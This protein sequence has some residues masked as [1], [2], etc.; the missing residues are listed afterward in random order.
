MTTRYTLLPNLTLE[1]VNKTLRRSRILYD[2]CVTDTQESKR[3]A[4]QTHITGTFQV[5]TN[6]FFL[7]KF[8]KCIVHFVKLCL[9]CHGAAMSKSLGQIK[10]C[11]LYFVLFV[12]GHFL[13]PIKWTTADWDKI[14]AFAWTWIY[15]AQY[16]NRDKC[17]TFQILNTWW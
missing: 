3:D 7:F 4:W 1:T 17:C 16:F 11:S 15:F 13:L 14:F 8:Q 6:N 5:N 2:A 9:F 12:I 10:Y